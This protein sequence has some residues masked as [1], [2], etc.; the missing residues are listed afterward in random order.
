MAQYQDI[1]EQQNFSAVN[2]AKMYLGFEYTMRSKWWKESFSKGMMWTGIPGLRSIGYGRG[3]IP[4]ERN[5]VGRALDKIGYGAVN[6]PIGNLLKFFKPNSGLGERI[7][8]RGVGDNLFGRVLGGYQ[9]GFGKL[10][11][12]MPLG[13]VSKI[14]EAMS[15]NWI[16]ALW[17]DVTD[18]RR[19]LIKS[20]ETGS[21]KLT[22]GRV[23][24]YKA[25]MSKSG[26]WKFA[27][28]QRIAPT[29]VWATNLAALASLTAPLFSAAGQ[30]V[31][32]KFEMA[33]TLI[34]KLNN[35]QLEFGGR[36]HQSYMNQTGMTERQRALQE[37]RTSRT[38]ARTLIGQE[39]SLYHV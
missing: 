17:G 18:E 19:Q 32:G 4:I 1:Q 20:M 24:R 30:F 16:R 29:L 11:P 12:V 14:N 22:L 8:Q 38:N 36:I 10:S 21:G 27:A 7:L 6:K 35:R 25:A 9:T 23:G 13:Q 15:K 31:A 37:L 39:A 28:S 33:N 5:I 3:A 34:D 26:A 2:L